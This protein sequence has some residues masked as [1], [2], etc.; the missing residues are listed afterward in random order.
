MNGP[1]LDLAARLEAHAGELAA[2]L[3]DEI[4]K[5]VRFGRGEARRT[6]EKLRLSVRR[7]ASLEQSVGP[8]MLRR[9]PHGLVAVVTPWNNPIYLSLGKIACAVLGGN[10]VV[11]KPAPEARRLSRRLF[12][13]LSEAGWPDGLV[14]LAEGGRERA[15]EILNDA[16]VAAVTITGSLAA[17]ATAREA[18]AR[19]GVPL[20]AELGGNNA[21]VVWP[22]ADQ[23]EAARQ[24]AA[25]AFEMAGQRCTANRRVVVLRRDVDA[26]VERLCRHAAAL[27]WG[28]PRDEAT[29]IGPLVSVAHRDRVAAF[30]ARAGDAIHPLGTTPPDGDR[31]WFPPVIVRGDDP[32][33]EAVQEE[34]FGPVLVVQTADDWDGAMRLCD[35]VRHGLA[36]AVFTSSPERA[37]RFLDEAQAGIVKVNQSTA[38]AAVDVPFGGWKASGIGTPEHGAFDVEF[39][40]RPQTVY[41][42]VRAA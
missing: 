38:D 41:G 18:C 30:V 26:F 28:D 35:G 25:G 7:F 39:F 29:Q 37:A 23:D 11:W 13:M 42:V 34:T 40:T 9:R 3:A 1:V 15:V 16:A 6:A 8:A 20:Q 24:I 32:A 4:G 10:S 21:A 5:P 17:G 22:D 19:R 31:A 14:R 12:A 36:A 33:S 2:L 27:V